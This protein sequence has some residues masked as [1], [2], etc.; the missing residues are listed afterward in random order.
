[1][2]RPIIRQ[3]DIND[4][5]ANDLI[6]FA[7]VVSK[8]SFTLAADHASLPKSTVSRRITDLENLLGE[9]LLT[10]TT[11][12]LTL[13]D[14]GERILEHAKQII[15][16]TEAAK[17]LALHRQATPQG[18][19]RISLPAEFRELSLDAVI[20]R[21]RYE[22][23]QVKLNLDLS[24]RRVDLVAERFDLA[25]RIASVLPDDNTLIARRIASLHNGLYASPAYLRRYGTPNSPQDLISHIG[26]ILITSGGELQDWDLRRGEE[27]WRGVPEATLSSNALGLQQALASEGMGIVALS[28]KF[29]NPSVE[30]GHLARVLPDWD[31]PEQTIWC[32]MPG[33][34]LLPQRTRTFIE[35]FTQVMQG[36]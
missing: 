34:R 22:H 23:P 4:L 27:R 9:R 19:L 21:F 11:R 10:R 20:K 14:F 24:A 25:V 6:L 1:M 17:S 35:I 30:Q 5:S 36:A 2:P 15:E 3:A 12:K 8:E 13:T 32:V 18:T 31:L 29:A 33:R 7:L 16:E 28:H 26:L